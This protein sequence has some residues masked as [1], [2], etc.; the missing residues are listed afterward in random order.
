ML[1]TSIPTI[2]IHFIWGE[3]KCANLLQCTFD[4]VKAETSRVTL[5]VQVEG[6]VINRMPEM[7]LLFTALNETEEEEY[8]KIRRHRTLELSIKYYEG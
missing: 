6:T 7:Y 2:V 3:T 1:C 5:I 8:D 4:Q